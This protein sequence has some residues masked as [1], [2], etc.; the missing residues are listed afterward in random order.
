MREPLPDDE[1][2]VAHAGAP[3]MDIDLRPDD[4]RPVPATAEGIDEADDLP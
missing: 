4:E 1:W 2:P 3:A